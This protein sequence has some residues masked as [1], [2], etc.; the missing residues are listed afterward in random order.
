MYN[1]RAATRGELMMRN[2]FAERFAK[3]K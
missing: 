3:K 1:E 2:F